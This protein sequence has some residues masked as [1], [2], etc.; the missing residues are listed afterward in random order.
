MVVSA[1]SDETG[2]LIS[3]IKNDPSNLAMIES[4]LAH[5]EGM[6]GNKSRLV[7]ARLNSKLRICGSPLCP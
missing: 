1:D 3:K 2:R 4:P 7:S 5:P 6:E